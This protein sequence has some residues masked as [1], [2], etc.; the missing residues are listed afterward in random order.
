VE[1]QWGRVT[2][3]VLQYEV[4]WE[5]VGPSP[6]LREV[7]NHNNDQYS[8]PNISL[9]QLSHETL[10]TVFMSYKIWR[11]LSLQHRH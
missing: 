7:I 1:D 10:L 6:P 3:V 11:F 4:H 9:S 5:D 2:E 8:G